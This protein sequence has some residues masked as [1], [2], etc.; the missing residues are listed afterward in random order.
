MST[1]EVYQIVMLFNYKQI[2][3]PVFKIEGKFHLGMYFASTNL[4]VLL[5]INFCDYY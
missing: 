2:F 5:S 1:Y 4:L 3:S